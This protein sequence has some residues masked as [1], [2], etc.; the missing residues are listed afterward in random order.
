MKQFKSKIIVILQYITKFF[1]TALRLLKLFQV[2]V[3]SEEKALD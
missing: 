3:S 2:M 1:R